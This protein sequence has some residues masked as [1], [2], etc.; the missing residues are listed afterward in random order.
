M[1]LIAAGGM[2]DVGKERKLYLPLNE[3]PN[4]P[5]K[6]DAIPCYDVEHGHFGNIFQTK[7]LRLS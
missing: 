4:L 5:G 1:R 3:H 6:C 7:A 2:E